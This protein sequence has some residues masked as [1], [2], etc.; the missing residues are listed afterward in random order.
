MSA[1]RFCRT[2]DIGLLVDA[3][4]RCGM[5]PPMTPAAFR[6]SIRDLQ[7]WCSSCMVAFSGADAIGVL[8]GAKRVSETLI[9]RIAVHPDHRRQGHGRHLLESMASKL[10]ILGPPRL[11]AEV[12]EALDAARGL[13]GAC[14]YVE[15]AV[16]TD[17]VLP[18]EDE[19][20]VLQT[21]PALSE[22]GNTARVEGFMMPVTA[23]DLAA[24][25]LLEP[26][27]APAGQGPPI[28][29]ERSVET[30]TARKD[31]LQGFAV[32]SDEGI[33]AYL[34][35]RRVGDALELS[36]LRSLID[37]G[38]ARLANLL[39]LVRAR[40]LEPIWFPRV[41]PAE[42]QAEWLEELGFCPAGKHRRFARTARPG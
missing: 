24:N 3:L 35:Y 31:D 8:I 40:G 32:A 42:I 39:A 21:R 36:A 30:L 10:A 9:H 23:D 22:R 4:N 41:H 11:V 13:F 20:A 1:Y 28:C 16:L 6:R 2:D 17:Y 25:G 27:T 19:Q 37:D 12:P 33:E 26:P 34:L 15:E 38:G 5:D 18:R 14:G 29:W 7:V